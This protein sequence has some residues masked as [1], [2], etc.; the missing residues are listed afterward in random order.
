MTH[1]ANLP[2]LLQ[3]FFTERLMHQRP[4]HYPQLSP[5]QR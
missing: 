5:I 1:E 3:G 2:R 4:Y